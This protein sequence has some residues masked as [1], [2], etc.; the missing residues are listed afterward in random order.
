MFDNVL[1]P[2]SSEVLPKKALLRGAQFNKKFGSKIHLQF[3]VEEKVFKAIDKASAHALAPID[4]ERVK[5]ELVDLMHSRVSIYACSG[6]EGTSFLFSDT[7]HTILYTFLTK[8]SRFVKF[9]TRV[10][11]KFDHIINR[12]KSY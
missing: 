9:I 11:A 6:G 10:N 4:L 3:I 8:Y 2:V 7:L 1:I 5:N 12:Y